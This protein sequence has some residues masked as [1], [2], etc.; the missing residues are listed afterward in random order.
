MT[1][2]VAHATTLPASGSFRS[3]DDGGHPWPRGTTLP[4]GYV[5]ERVLGQ[6]GFAVV[7]EATHP[8]H[9]LVAVKVLDQSVANV[10]ATEERFFREAEIAAAVDHSNVLRVFEL[11]RAHDGSPFLVMEL[12]RGQDLSDLIE[13]QRLSVEATVEIGVQLTQAL[14][15]LSDAGVIHRDLK[16]H[17][18]LI[19]DDKGTIRAKVI[20][21]G[22]ATST[23]DSTV[24]SVQKLTKTGIILGTPHY[25]SPEQARGEDLDVRADLYAL[26]VV[27]Y[28]AHCGRAPFEDANLNA[29][30]ASVLRDDRPRITQFAPECP[31]ALADILA[32]AL[33]RDKD[34]RYQTPA[35]LL[36]ALEAFAESEGLARGQRALDALRVSKSMTLPWELR[37][38][39]PCKRDD[40]S[41]PVPV[42]A[43]RGDSETPREVTVGRWDGRETAGWSGDRKSDL[44]PRPIALG[45]LENDGKPRRFLAPLAA[46]AGVVIGLGMAG[47]LGASE[48]APSEAHAAAAPA[49]LPSEAEGEPQPSEDSSAEAGEPTEAAAAVPAEAPPTPSDE[50]AEE[51]APRRTARAPA[52]SSGSSASESA[53]SGP[54]VGTLKSQARQAYIRGR[55]GRARGLYRRATILDGNDGEAW[56]GYGLVAAQMGEKAEARRALTRY[57]SL[58]PSARD[59][60][61]IRRR[62]AQL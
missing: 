30:I 41:I 43:T 19:H 62:L 18:V 39:A 7:Y 12:L 9:G 27:L 53:P 5:I 13:Q 22:I 58:S 40:R 1:Q 38:L 21:F 35:E 3:P 20:D 60:S 34:A 44:T 15:A 42:R 29:L 61:A 8:D 51:P 59:A 23:E 52:A 25:L 46:A 10:E 14:A 37:N 31:E 54:S 6:G 28:E 45:P 26:G 2:A 48:A 4:G 47:F 55:L 17:N 16:P 24:T 11:G 57:L 49:E 50:R 33:E 36:E 56:R 32:K